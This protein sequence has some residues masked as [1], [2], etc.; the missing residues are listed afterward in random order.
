MAFPEQ[1]ISILKCVEPSC[2]RQNV[3]EYEDY[4][5]KI[6]DPGARAALTRLRISAH[7][8]NIEV[9]R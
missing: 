7:R 4:L 8:L 3:F 1:F 5:T 2:L 6:H 9:G